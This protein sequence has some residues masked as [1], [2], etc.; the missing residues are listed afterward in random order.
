M[1]SIGFVYEREYDNKKVVNQVDYIITRSISFEY[2]KC[3][4]CKKEILEMFTIE[5]WKNSELVERKDLCKN[6]FYHEFRFLCQYIYEFN[7]QKLGI[8]LHRLGILV[9]KITNLK[10]ECDSLFC[11]YYAKYNFELFPLPYKAKLCEACLKR[12]IGRVIFSCEKY[13]DLKTKT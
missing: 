12:E 4:S 2:R 5:I 6:C 13:L 8:S 9:E 7:W 1:V 11:D 3:N 10:I